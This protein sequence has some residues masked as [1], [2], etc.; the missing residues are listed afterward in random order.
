[1]RTVAG[2]F[3][4]AIS[5][6][7]IKICELY[8]FELQNGDVYRY[9]SHS[10][11]I[12]WESGN[13][14]TAV[15]IVRGP[16]AYTS[17]FESDEV[18]ISFARVGIDFEDYIQQNILEGVTVTIKRIPWNAS[19][20][21]DQ[22]ITLFIGVGD[23]VF[24]RQIVSATCRPDYDRL[25]IQVPR[26]TFQEPCN[27]SLFDDNCGLTQSDYEQQGTATGG[28]DLT[29]ID[30]TFDTVYKIAFDNGDSDN[31]IAIGD[32][33]LGSIGAGSGLVVGIVYLDASTGFLWF[34]EQTGTLFVDDETVSVDS[35]GGNS[36]DVNMPDGLSSAEDVYFYMF[37]EL[38]IRSGTNSGQRRQIQEVSTNVITVTYPF[39]V[40]IEA[41]VEYS[42]YP[43]CDKTSDS[44]RNKFGNETKFKGFLYV[45]KYE[46][47]IM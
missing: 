27:H 39:P 16:L 28:T 8:K 41:G 44:C 14:Y 12:V 30:T 23:I 20:A 17:S 47:T 25:N 15:P 42:I 13:T 2:T 43:G 36:V 22:E 6:D 24:D 35:G 11:D 46:E 26:H 10:K 40:A 7:V 9:T 32:T 1:M 29:L 5:Q 18:E 33:L 34:V 37:G 4:T 38:E 3:E 31:P 19:Y 21:A 45:P